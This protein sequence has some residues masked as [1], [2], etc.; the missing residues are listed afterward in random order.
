[1]ADRVAELRAVERVE[2]EVT[3]AARV[4][5]TAK[6]RGHRCRDELAGGG[7][8]VQSLEQMAEPR[9]DS[10]PAIGGHPHDSGK[11]GDRHDARDDLDIDA[12][13][14]DFV[15]ETQETVWR[16]EELSDRAVRPRI[17]LS[18]Q[19]IDVRRAP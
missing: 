5:V 19:M 18:L 2:M 9:R 6:L 16:E 14:G 1:M 10:S 11:I 12:C 7:E 8:V 15:L 17:A 13:G 4:E 3:D